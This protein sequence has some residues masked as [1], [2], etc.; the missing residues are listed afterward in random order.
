M[1]FL[2]QAAQAVIKDGTYQRLFAEWFADEPPPELE[3]LTGTSRFSFSGLLSMATILPRF[4]INW[5]MCPVFPPR[6]AQA[7]NTVSPGRGFS[8][9]EMS[10]AA[11]S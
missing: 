4:F 3:I 10:C 2:Q 8:A 6:P 5:A 7:S 11:S 1:S 9:R